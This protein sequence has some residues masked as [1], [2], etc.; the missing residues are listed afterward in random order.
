MKLE[1][2]TTV[3]EYGCISP[4]FKF[5]GGYSSGFLKYFF[6]LKGKKVKI[7]IEVIE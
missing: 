2:T 4:T 7:T 6:F 1:A 5:E 3:D